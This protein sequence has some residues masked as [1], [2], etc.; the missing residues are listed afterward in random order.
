MALGRWGLL[1]SLEEVGCRVLR[2]QPL[3]M[4]KF[5]VCSRSGP[6]NHLVPLGGPLSLL[7][8][9]TRSLLAHFLP[10]LSSSLFPFSYS[11]VPSWAPFLVSF[12]IS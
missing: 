3:G 6:R 2:D 9:P 8:L 11:P 1:R 5:L 12:P 4:L 7:P 10:P